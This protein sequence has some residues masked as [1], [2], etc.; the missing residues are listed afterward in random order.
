M[1]LQCHGHPH[2]FCSCFIPCPGCSWYFFH[3]RKDDLKDHFVPAW[4]TEQL[5]FQAAILGVIPHRH[6]CFKQLLVVFLQAMRGYFSHDSQELR[7]PE[8][9]NRC[10]VAAQASLEPGRERVSVRSGV[11]PQPGTGR[12]CGGARKAIS[13]PLR[14]LPLTSARGNACI[15]RQAKEKEEWKRVSVAMEEVYAGASKFCPWGEQQRSPAEGA[16]AKLRPQIF[17]SPGPF[18]KF[19]LPK[20][21]QSA[22]FNRLALATTF[23][24]VSV[25]AMPASDFYRL[26]HCIITF[27]HHGSQTF[28][29]NGFCISS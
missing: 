1:C 19:S 10:S 24:W 4:R 18:C 17:T 12:G 28:P 15:G 11:A 20:A 13:F 29:S 16:A 9:G 8:D 27:T 3:L 5:L 25:P 26:T 21:S 2:L 22:F 7:H 14:R 6:L 23:A